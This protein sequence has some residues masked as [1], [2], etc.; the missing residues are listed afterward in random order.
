MSS[1]AVRRNRLK[2]RTIGAHRATRRRIAKISVVKSNR[3]SKTQTQTSIEPSRVCEQQ[4]SV[5]AAPAVSN[6]SHLPSIRPLMRRLIPCVGGGKAGVLQ[7]LRSAWCRIS[8]RP[9]KRSSQ[10]HRGRRRQHRSRDYPGTP[11][12]NQ[13][14]RRQCV[15]P[16]H[17]QWRDMG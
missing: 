10:G 15:I 16:G 1:M 3:N 6:P 17:R 7:R 2:T 12:S 4:K 13:R 8:S 14:H 5:F 9:A 11:A